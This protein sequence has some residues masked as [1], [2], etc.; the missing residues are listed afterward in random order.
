MNN[1]KYVILFLIVI[2]CSSSSSNQYN[3]TVEISKKEF[4]VLFIGNS[5]IYTNNL[6]KIVEKTA[7]KKGVVIHSKTIA[8]PNYCLMDHWDDGEI[9]EEIAKNKYDFVIIQQG[10][11]SQAYGRK[12]LIE[13]GAKINKIC[14][15]Y[16]SK[17]GFFMVWPSLTYY[18]TFDG[19]IKNYRDASI[20]NNSILFPV[21]EIWKEHFDSIK[22]FDYYSADGFHPSL[23]GSHISAEIIVEHL[24]MEYQKD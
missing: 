7:K 3:S 6:P 9:Q 22:S 15:K 13:Y 23:K 1:I 8:L 4:K 19:V 21:G 17:L 24:L 10:P 5:L 11:S 20:I 16:G 18:Q 2:V 14:N 12:I